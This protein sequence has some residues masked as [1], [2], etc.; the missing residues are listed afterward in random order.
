MLTPRRLAACAL[1]LSGCV[2]PF[3]GPLDD[4]ELACDEG[5]LYLAVLG[6]DGTHNLAVFDDEPQ[7]GRVVDAG[8][9]LEVAGVAEGA[10]YTFT[11]T[12]YD[13]V[14]AGEMPVGP[15]GTAGTVELELEL[16]RP[17]LGRFELTSVDGAITFEE[18]EDDLLRAAF[19]ADL[20]APGN[21]FNGCFELA[22]APPDPLRSAL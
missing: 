5:R 8:T 9:K 15:E 7:P 17:G 13:L 3:A 21:T 4:A 20:G 10:T 22:V 2:E 18:V 16:S 14:R 11:L 12:G 6:F 1:A 19:S